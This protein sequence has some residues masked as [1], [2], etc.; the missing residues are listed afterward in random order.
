MIEKYRMNSKEILMLETAVPNGQRRL[1][2]GR[3]RECLR[4]VAEVVTG[5]RIH[6]FAVQ[7]HGA[8]QRH[9]LVEQAGRGRD[10]SARGERLHEPERTRQ[11]GAFGSRQ[12]IAPERVAVQERSTGSQR[13]AD[14][15]DRAS[16][17]SGLRR[18]D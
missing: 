12:P 9:E 18:L 2:D 6:L 11:E 10:L 3:M 16:Y 5:A 7:P 14:R 13:R 8:R 4:E 17:S 1:D 15:V